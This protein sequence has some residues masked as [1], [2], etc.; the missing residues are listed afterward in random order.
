M[1]T[2]RN[3][4]F[5]VLALQADLIT[6]A[7]FA[8]ACSAWA[9]R[10]TDPLADLLV[11]RRWLTPVDCADVVKL[12]ERKLKKRNGDVRASLAEVVSDAIRASLAESTDSA[13]HASLA[14]LIPPARSVLVSTGD[15]VPESR[16]RYKLSRLHATGGLGR[17]WLAHD[18][19]LN[20]DVA[21][22]E[23]RPE[24][25]DN[26]A[27]WSRFLKEAQITGQLEHPG[28]VPVYELARR[29]TDRAPYYTMRFVRGRT[30]AEAARSFHQRRRQNE[31]G[32]LDFRQL[33][34]AFV[35]VCHAVAYAHSKGVV[36]RDLKPQ[37]VA[38]GDFGEV[39]VLD[40]GLAKVIGSP[41]APEDL[42]IDVDAQ[43]AEAAT[44][45]GQVLGTPAYMAPEQ[46]EG[47]LDLLD[48]RSDVY[49]L[50]AILYELLAGRPPF[51]GDD[52]QDVL[53]RVRTLNPDS[54]RLAWPNA[55][56][57]LEAICRKAMAK[58]REGRYT[59]AGELALEVQHWLA[60]EPI[61]VYRE[62]LWTRAARWGRRHRPL[63]TGAAAML[64]V[65][66]AALTIGTLL[67]QRANRE[68]ALERDA[69][70][71]ER[72][73]ADVSYRQARRAVD[74]V[75]TRF[76]D[77]LA[78]SPG[79]QPIRRD[80]LE[81]AL[82]YY[83]EFVADRS[84]DPALRAELALAHWRSGAIL[85]EISTPEA[86]SAAFRKAMEIQEQLVRE[87][88]D[89]LE[90][91][92][93]LA[94][95]CNN[96][97]LVLAGTGDAE[98]GLALIRRSAKLR[99]ELTRQDPTSRAYRRNVA[100]TYSNLASILDRDTTH[101]GAP[102]SE[103]LR[104]YELALELR[105]QLAAAEPDNLA[106]QDEL[107]DTYNNL[108]AWHYRNG[109][110]QDAL[111]YYEQARNLRG[112][113]RSRQDSA[114]RRFELA[115]TLFNIGLLRRMTVK[116]VEALQALDQSAALLGPLVSENPKVTEY[117][118]LLA[119]AA[120]GLGIV[121]ADAGRQ[122]KA[123]DAFQ[124]ATELREEIARDN[125]G[126]RPYREELGRAHMNLGA[127]LQ[128]ADQ[129]AEAELALHR[130][131]EVYQQLMREVPGDT[132]TRANLALTF[133]NLGAVQSDRADGE[134]ALV[135]FDHA[136]E[137]YHKLLADEPENTGYWTG[138]ANVW[139]NRGIAL[140]KLD[141]WADALKAYRQ[142]VDAQKAA[143]ARQPGQ[144]RYRHL[145]A[146]NLL[147][148]AEA[149]RKVKRPA[150]ALAALAECVAL[151][152]G[153]ANGLYDVACGLSLCVPL[154]GKDNAELSP[155]VVGDR[156]MVVLK[157]AVTA[158]YRDSAHMKKDA[159]LDPLRGRPDFQLLLKTLDDPPREP[160][161][162]P[163]RL[164]P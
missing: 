23:V 90:F 116:P 41:D 95:S 111:D 151:R 104:H 14:G 66:V 79:L 42:P 83:Q 67:L 106:F 150:D 163:R 148:V 91:R 132:A 152:A 103:A 32:S 11:E 15:F 133:V 19:P 115:K 156:A 2:D 144:P 44:V 153:N 29:A 43:P 62:P 27:V 86:A 48:A 22:K 49:G 77:R 82:K 73:R 65:S 61:V 138:L 112:Q 145:L 89:E 57:A 160:G 6:P 88:P 141:R 59:T 50:G 34:T 18:G 52:T 7:Q 40:W 64:V 113:L 51:G 120:N 72:D 13:I 96:L 102:A 39:M 119:E 162:P 4:L 70:N 121:H 155:A 35:G 68:T 93:D 56:R 157:A 54:P 110:P 164:D 92:N 38:L 55:P 124:K 125:P 46:A 58:K 147:G 122:T 94:A 149:S 143:L 12:L 60:D 69:A 136:D 53:A 81:A 105:K 10:K 108:G 9:S 142:A 80:L 71:R 84:D 117:R 63:V 24:R 20:R 127:M 76:S 100:S 114:L 99:E 129:F 118:R 31:G 21:L 98:A 37:N 8:E 137:E 78:G 16:D 154:I 97:G 1:D 140:G 161:P 126:I 30:L 85:N 47:R 159:D 131:L 101:G 107:G 139:D 25:A 28:I 3:L 134:Q 109:R 5:G 26:P 130:A 87:H 146:E 36:H 74:E 45:Q 75:Y 123:L 128:K 17:V 33:V 135:N 158:G